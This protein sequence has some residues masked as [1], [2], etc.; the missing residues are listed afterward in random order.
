MANSNIPKNLTNTRQSHLGEYLT[1]P[2]AH[3][4]ID[5]YGD[6]PSPD[7]QRGHFRM[8][9]CNVNGIS[10][11]HKDQDSHQIGS[12]ADAYHIDCVGLAET[13][14]NWYNAI[15]K[16]TIT[17]ILRKYWRKTLIKTSSTPTQHT[18]VSYTHLTL[19]TIA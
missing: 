13:N 19:P 3:E 5:T 14:I 2:N 7:K 18:P 9:F 11:T 6:F 4:I 17:Q 15:A 10:T 12:T 16:S 8:I 1:Q